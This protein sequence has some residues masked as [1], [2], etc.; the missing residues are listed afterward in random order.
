MTGYS[1]EGDLVVLRLTREDFDGLLLRLGRAAA[2]EQDLNAELAFINRLCS[3]N[4]NFTPYA[5]EPEG[6]GLR[7]S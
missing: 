6:E 2:G 3:G 7:N 1:E 5:I 4:P